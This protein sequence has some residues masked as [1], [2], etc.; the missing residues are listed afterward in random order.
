LV[1]AQKAA[2]L[3]SHSFASSIVGKLIW[4]AARA[5]GVRA[6]RFTETRTAVE[7]ACLEVT[8]RLGTFPLPQTPAV[9]GGLRLHWA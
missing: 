2:R 3:L 8:E 4:S 6:E 5:L 7:A 1:V 9:I